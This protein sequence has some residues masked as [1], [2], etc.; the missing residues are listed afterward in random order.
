MPDYFY[1]AKDED[2]GQQRFRVRVEPQGDHWMATC[3]PVDEAG[4]VLGTGEKVAP[5]F[6]GTH[7][8]QARRQMV[9]ALENTYEDVIEQSGPA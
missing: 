7:E 2:G 4:S 3:S 5:Q 1:L 9:R 8:D 6:Y